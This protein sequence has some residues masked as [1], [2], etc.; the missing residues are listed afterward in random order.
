MCACVEVSDGG[1]WGWDT[2]LASGWKN[3]VIME[4]N[5]LILHLSLFFVIEKNVNE[6]F[7]W[8]G[9]GSDGLI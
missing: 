6:L 2:E 4:L 7:T 5:N 8:E 3:L 1:A 9:K